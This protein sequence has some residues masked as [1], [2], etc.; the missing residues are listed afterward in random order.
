MGLFSGAAVLNHAFPHLVQRTLPREFCHSCC[1]KSVAS[2]RTPELWNLRDT[3][4]IS[5]LWARG[6]QAGFWAWAYGIPGRLQG[7]CLFVLILCLFVPMSFFLHHFSPSSLLSAAFYNLHGGFCRGFGVHQA[8]C[9]LAVPGGTHR[10]IS[11][12]FSAGIPSSPQLERECLNLGQKI[13]CYF[14]ALTCF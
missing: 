9:C 12:D 5:L 7:M 14:C 1:P 11:V 3:L 2:S 10:R 4:G 6:F 8:L 13:S